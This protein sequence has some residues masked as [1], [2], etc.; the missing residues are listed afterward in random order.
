MLWEDLEA[1][2]QK[3]PMALGDWLRSHSTSQHWQTSEGLS[4]LWLY[5]FV[6]TRKTN[7]VC[8]VIDQLEAGS[9]EMGRTAFCFCLN[10]KA[11]T[12]TEKAFS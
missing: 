10:D 1:A 2:K 3:R 8:R 9:Q 6:G 7:L 5:G 11:N 12:G 4:M